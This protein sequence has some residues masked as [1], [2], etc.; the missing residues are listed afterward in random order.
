MTFD[1]GIEV[2][3]AVLAI[4]LVLCFVRLYIGPNVPN[5]TLAFDAIAIHG[6][7]ILALLSLRDDA[8]VMLDIA[9][10]TAVLGFLGTT[11]MAIYLE[12]SARPAG[13]EPEPDPTLQ[14]DPD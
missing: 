1:R 12:R 9:I 4:S 13:A 11:M 14:V 6:V 10:I 5:R 7:G 3:I 2:L 8:V